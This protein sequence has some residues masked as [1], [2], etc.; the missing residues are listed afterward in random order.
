MYALDVVRSKDTKA[1][2]LSLFLLALVLAACA[3]RDAAPAAPRSVIDPTKEP[4]PTGGKF[5]CVDTEAA[6]KKDPSFAGFHVI[7]TTEPAAALPPRTVAEKYAFPDHDHDGDGIDDEYD[8][9]PAS[10]EDGKEPHPFD[11]CAAEADHTKGRTHWPDLPRVI[12]KA[13]HIEITEQIHFALG[14]AKILESSKSLISAIAQ[15]IVDTPDIELVEVAGHADKQGNEKANVTLTNQRAKSVADALVAK[16][17]DA[18]WLRSMGYGEYCPLDPAGTK[19][20]LAKNRRVE[21][22]IL[23]RDGRELSPSWGGCDA[24]EKHGIHQPAMP[25]RAARPKPIKPVA[26][27]AVKGA[28]DFHGSCHT[29]HAPECEKDCKDGSIEACYVGAH[30]RSHSTEGSA[31]LANRDALKKECETGLFP[32]CG[33]LATSL[34]LEP[35][36]DHA[37]ALSFA[38]NACDKGDGIGCGV[39]SFL[40]ERGCSVPPDAGKG[41]ELAKKGCAVDITHAREHMTSS[42]ADRLS[43][44]VASNSLWWGFGGAKDHAAAYAFDQRA[45]AAGLRHAC[46]RLAQDALSEPALVTDR[47]K[48]VATLHDACE[49]E[50]WDVKREECIALANIEKAGEYSSPRL[51]EA[52]GQ[53]E[54]IKRC[55]ARDWEPCMDLYISALYRGCYRRVETLSPR[56]W[57]LRGLIEEAKTDHYKDSQAKLDEVASENYSKACSATVPSGCIHHARMRL[58]G[59]GQYRDPAG[60]SKALEEWCTKGEKMACAFLAHAAATK[61]IPGGK[62]EAKKRMAEACKAGLTRACGK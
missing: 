44:N 47:A 15:A 57:V 59:R 7:N 51:C 43:C 6:M 45:C 28:P 12:V 22:R 30:E 11:G 56:G 32:A 29:P 37:S 25:P 19:E 23:R 13:D 52:G 58:E 40:L 17:V 39:A 8:L 53:L 61:K 5:E 48:L 54:C 41:Y 20:A 9:C 42:I 3:G 14:S 2:G 31:I 1:T 10:S 16:G 55:D 26:I 49:Q 38:T 60:A 34:L 18:K 27:T 62:E 36:Q 35:P 33:Q 4:M 21:F 46:V 24:A 50:G